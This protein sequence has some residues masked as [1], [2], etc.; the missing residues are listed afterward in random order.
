MDPT[1]PPD[2]QT[3]EERSGDDQPFLDLYTVVLLLVTAAAIWTA[4]YNPRL[5]AAIAFGLVVFA[6]LRKH[7]RR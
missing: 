3:P 1:L 4:F 6:A 2:K 5:A 7:L